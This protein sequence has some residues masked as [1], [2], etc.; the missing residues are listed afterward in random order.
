MN[1][2]SPPLR[3]G[4]LSSRDP[5][6]RRAWSGVMHYL[7]R[8][9]SAHCGEVIAL[10]PVESARRKRL[11]TWGKRFRPV[12]GKRYDA[13]HSI[14][15]SME[16]ARL[17]ASKLS[18][19][20][21]DVIFAPSASTEIAFLRTDIPI[22]YFSDATF[23]ALWGYYDDFA[24]LLGVSR[25]EGNLVERRAIQ[26]SARIIYTSEWAKASAIQDYAA[27][28]SKIEVVPFGANLE[29]PPDR[30]SLSTRSRAD[31]LRLLFIGVDWQRKGGPIAVEAFQVLQAQGIRV[32]LTIVG[33]RP[34]GVTETADLKIIPFLDNNDPLQARRIADLYLSADMLIVPTRADCAGIVFCEAAAYG[35]PAI[36]THTGGVPSVV[37]NEVTGVM[38]APEAR[39][40][41]YAEAIASLWHDERRLAAMASASRNAFETRLN[42]D[43]WGI[44]AARVI[45]S[46]WSERL[47]GKAVTTR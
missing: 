37:E 19:N 2:S 9:L 10:G 17:F 32:S 29:S 40:K 34:P 13:G 28:A 25:F 4:F 47:S 26:K 14:L 5:G 6:D 18:R 1:D 21:V 35:L 27:D 31:H 39:G 7:A 22:V 36:T 38:L 11:R 15:V 30:G 24:D 12:L 33:C 16:Y 20:P 42:W 3:I 44:S 46:A 41:D 8:T 45:R 23:A 43:A